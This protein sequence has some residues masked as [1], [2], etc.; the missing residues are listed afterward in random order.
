M[1]ASW[2]D[3]RRLYHDIREISEACG[4]GEQRGRAAAGPLPPPHL[5]AG[6]ITQHQ[7]TCAAAAPGS[8]RTTLD[9]SYLNKALFTHSGLCGTSGNWWVFARQVRV[10]V[11]VTL[12]GI[13]NS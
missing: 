9:Y 12:I 7:H 1:G 3:H 4:P 11:D 8:V 2:S 6:V 13:Y 5:G 10:H